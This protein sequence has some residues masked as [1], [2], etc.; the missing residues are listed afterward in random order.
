MRHA[1]NFPIRLVLFLLA[2]TF[3]IVGIAGAQAQVPPAR[4]LFLD[5]DRVFKDSE[6]GKDIRGQLEGM[7][8]E[9]QK[10]ADAAETAFSERERTLIASAQSRPEAD[11]RADYERLQ[12]ERAG[13][14][15]MFQLRRSAVQAA[16]TQARL[17]VSGV[18]NEIFKEVLAERGANMIVDRSM[19]LIGGTDYEITSEVIARLNKRMPT[20]KVDMPKSNN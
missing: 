13:S 16:S 7:L 6:V 9:I 19:V 15:Q 10:E 3:L 1:D 5:I 17:K 11:V 8:G 14:Q 2:A 4:A 12:T 20:L 18:L